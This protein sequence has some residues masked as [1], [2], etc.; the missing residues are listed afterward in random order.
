MQ[1]LIIKRRASIMLDNYLID[2]TKRIYQEPRKK[3]KPSLSIEI[4]DSFTDNNT[5]HKFFKQQKNP[6][7]T[8]FISKHPFNFISFST[9]EF[10]PLS[11]SPRNQT[12]V[13]SF[14]ISEPTFKC[15]ID[16]QYD[17][18]YFEEDCFN[19]SMQKCHRKIM[20]DRVIIYLN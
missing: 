19:I 10:C 13:S 1:N 11:T 7:S 5:N 4:H 3:F 6:N 12:E 8:S 20:E 15:E 14:F 16:N 2:N 18:Y 17:D 9:D